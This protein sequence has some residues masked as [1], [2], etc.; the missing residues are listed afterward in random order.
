MKYRTVDNREHK[1]NTYYW[2]G[3]VASTEQSD[4]NQSAVS[5]ILDEAGGYNYALSLRKQNNYFQVDEEV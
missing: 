5:S 4:V 2:D 1:E 3:F